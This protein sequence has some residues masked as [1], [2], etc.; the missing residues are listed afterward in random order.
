MPRSEAG[1]I[2]R[3]RQKKQ[4]ALTKRRKVKERL[5]EERKPKEQCE[6]DLVEARMELKTIRKE[7]SSQQKISV[8]LTS[9]SKCRLR[10]PRMVKCG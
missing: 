5:D 7:L 3:K 10:K 6:Q 2:R 9:V 1:K 8:L 4:S